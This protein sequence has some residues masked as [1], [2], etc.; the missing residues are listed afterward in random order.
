[1]ASWT[2]GGGVRVQEGRGPDLHRRTARGQEFERILGAHDSAHPDERDVG[3]A[4]RPVGE[5]HRET[6]NRRAGK[7]ARAEAPAAAGTAFRSIDMPTN[8]FAGYTALTFPRVCS[9]PQRGH[10][11]VP[12]FGGG[13]RI[14][15][16]R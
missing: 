10:F 6:A 12:P 11:T 9:A 16:H 4:R 13:R 14:I 7:A 1:M 3:S 15:P 8:V 5:V 2:P